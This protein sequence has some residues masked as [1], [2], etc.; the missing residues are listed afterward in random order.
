MVDIQPSNGY[1]YTMIYRNITQKILNALNDTP[2]V[3]ING[4]RQTGKSTLVRWIADN[5]YP[6]EYFSLDDLSTLNSIKQ[7]PVDFI[8]SVKGPLII[9]EVQKAPELFSA[10]KMEV[11]RDRRPGRFIL[12][13]SAN[14][15]LLPAISESLAGRMEIITL[16]PFS[17]S[18]LEGVKNNFVD[19]L[20]TSGWPATLSNYS[21]EPV[22]SLL[23]RITCGGYPEVVSRKNRERRDAWFNSYITTILQRDIRDIAKINGLTALPNLLSLL[24]ARAAA[25]FNFAD[26]SRVSTIPQ[27]TL[28]RYMSLLEMT[29]LV[30]KLPAWS[31]NINKRLLKSPKVILNDS[32]LHCFL[33]NYNP[34]EK[35]VNETQIGS[36][37][38]NFVIMELWKEISWSV[39]RPDI[40]HF[41]TQTGHKV[42]VVLQNAAGQLAAIEVKS[43]SSVSKNDFKGLEVLKE[44]LG[45][46]FIKGIL[47]YSG[48]KILPFGKKLFAVPISLIWSA[49][50]SQKNKL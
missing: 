38:E 35:T 22:K 24:A 3:F 36:I 26:F 15:L 47:F 9:D 6:A 20:F 29:F 44:S 39:I 43:K 4:A 12:T 41:R 45:E 49:P 25:L 2:V 34:E 21:T 48:E 32:A 42:D 23:S 18:E 8:R 11:D 19:L 17:Q 40:F 46:R 14:I 33:I 28:K 31:S 30:H 7:S 37:L 13:G 50:D 16:W 10:I 1:I 27:S 5:K